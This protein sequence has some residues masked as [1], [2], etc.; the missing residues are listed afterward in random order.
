MSRP[1]PG[2]RHADL[3]GRFTGAAI[4]AAMMGLRPAIEIMTIN[5]SLLAIDQIINN[6]AKPRSRSGGQVSVPLVLRT[7][8]GGGQQLSATTRGTW[9]CGTP[10]CP[11]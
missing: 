9:R 5:F 10:T 2:A 7:P 8:G 6:A 4:G 3:R 1:A 11:G